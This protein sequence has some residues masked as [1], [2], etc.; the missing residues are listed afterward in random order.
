MARSNGT[1]ATDVDNTQ[2]AAEQRRATLVA[3]RLAPLL[4]DAFHDPDAPTL[5]PALKLDAHG[6]ESVALATLRA[7]TQ[8]PGLAELFRNGT[9][10]TKGVEERLVQLIGHKRVRVR[11][12]DL[13]WATLAGEWPIPTGDTTVVAKAKRWRW[14]RFLGRGWGRLQRYLAAALLSS[15]IAALLLATEHY[16]ATWAWPGSLTLIELFAVAILSFF[17]GWL[18]VRFV[19]FRAGAVWDEYVLNLHR[20]GVDE[21]QH[22]P[23]PPI[24]S[25]YYPAWVAAGGPILAR[26]STI[27]QQKFDA[28]YGRSVSRSGGGTVK[29]EA[30]FPLFLFTAT[31][32]AG[33]TAVMWQDGVLSATAPAAYTSL[34]MMAFAFIGAY[35]FTIQMLVRRYFQSDLKSSAY[36]GSFVRTVVAVGTVAVL[37]RAGALG[38]GTVQAALA[39]VIGSFPL[40]GLQL[41]LRLGAKVAKLAVPVLDFPHPLSDIEGLSVWYEA[42]LLEEGIEDM[43]NLLTANLPEVILHTRVPVGRLVDWLDQAQLFLRLP[44]LRKE[45]RRKPMDSQHPRCALRRVGVRSASAFLDAF[46]L[47]DAGE[48]RPPAKTSADAVKADL[49]AAQLATIS[50]I[51]EAEPTMETVWRWRCW[52]SCLTDDGSAFRRAR[53]H[54]HRHETKAKGTKPVSVRRR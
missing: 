54:H 13:L 26:Q 17:P 12:A 10:G 18:F 49:G 25:V 41:L 46:P 21:P 15:V 4:V 31:V 51:I 29:L 38:D 32:A 14:V 11:Q 1:S 33:W 52:K 23:R 22:L 45:D 5:P 35:I 27:Y 36:A 20:L 16:A 53:A 6:D 28:Y 2:V 48:L 43:Q 7:L 24:N 30:L 44:P 50:R 37:D 9:R 40:M 47:D 42:R 3:S 39:F 19:G 34:D 8:D